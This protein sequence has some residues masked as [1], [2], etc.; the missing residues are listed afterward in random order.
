[1]P[2]PPLVDPKA[3]AHHLD[4]LVVPLT[5][6]SSDYKLSYGGAGQFQWAGGIDPYRYQLRFQVLFTTGGKQSHWVQFDA[7]QLLGTKLRV[8]ANVGYGRETLTPY[9]GLGNASSSSLR[10]HPEL[11]GPHPF[12]YD[13]MTP[14]ARA[15]VAYPILPNV[16]AFFF[17]AYLD[18]RIHAPQG[19]LL[20]EQR[21]YGFEGGHELQAMVGLYRNAR[22][23]EA[24]P[25][26]GSL[27]ELS[28]RGASR[29]MGSSYT[30]G[31]INARWLNFVSLSPRFVLATR[32]EGDL[33][34]HGTPF[35]QLAQFGGVAS[36]LGS[37]LANL[38]VGVIA[39]AV[40]LLAVEAGK[41]L[42]GKKAA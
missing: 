34:S 7:P 13:S 14:N 41:K 26:S 9:Y 24:A 25:T 37:M 38:L 12:T 39:G 29:A 23:Q 40:V 28:L 3:I 31:G 22:D 30:Y 1:M 21:V 2:R 42:L 6:Y 33:L 11:Y 15:G 27:L 10:D 32:L 17:G 16:H 18:E 36:A 8:W 20:N 5:S 19:S 4:W 35:Y